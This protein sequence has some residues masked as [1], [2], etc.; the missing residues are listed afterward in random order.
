MNK[1][2]LTLGSITAIV[3]GVIAALAVAGVFDSSSNAAPG[4]GEQADT[5]PLCVEGAENCDDMIA[6]PGDGD[7][8]PAPG[9][10]ASGTCPIGTSDCNDTPGDGDPNLPISDDG[11]TDE[12]KALAVEAALAALEAM[13]GPPANE[14]DA[15]EV[16][17][18]VWSNACLGVD[19][20][21]IACAQVITPGFV[22]VLD[23]GT[24][25]YTFHANTTGH[26]VLA[27]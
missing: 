5:A 7:D 27:E 20:P 17:F 26:A 4:N 15:A 24:T 25:A 12:G 23:T 8:A 11:E 14:V 18:E 9:D 2:P 16:H 19:T 1:W 3:I 6:I 21:G 13:G 22:V 10:G